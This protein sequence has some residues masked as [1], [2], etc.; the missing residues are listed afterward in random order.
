MDIAVLPE[1]P[2]DLIEKT[3]DG[4][5]N[6]GLKEGVSNERLII[7][8]RELNMSIENIGAKIIGS[9]VE[10][11]VHGIAISGDSNHVQFETTNSENSEELAQIGREI[12][13][14]LTQLSIDN[15]NDSP[16]VIATKAAEQ[17]KVNPEQKSKFRRFVKAV[18]NASGAAAEKMIDHPAA[19]FFTKFFEEILK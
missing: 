13:D 1:A 5:Y 6:T 19:T 12:Q 8:I 9:T 7:I 17:A 10:G 14:L 4:G 11:S 18:T 15:P 2:K 3:F 16:S